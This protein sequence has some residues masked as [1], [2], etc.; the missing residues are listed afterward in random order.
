[1]RRD[2]QGET[3]QEPVDVREALLALRE[4]ELDRRESWIRRAELACNAAVDEDLRD[5]EAAIVQAERRLAEERARLD[6]DDRE[7]A[8]RRRRLEAELAELAAARGRVAAA[9]EAFES[10]RSR[11]D[12]LEGE[13]EATRGAL[14]E[15]TRLL[16]EREA[17]ADRHAGL[18][19][20]RGS[21]ASAPGRQVP[22][23]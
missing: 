22:A 21:L 1:M 16:V 23:A 20:A 14:L 8:E 5:R 6:A 11:L 17:A 19:A 9:Q 12:R 15:R 18:L 3:F 7:A 10:A 13:L 2:G 4:A